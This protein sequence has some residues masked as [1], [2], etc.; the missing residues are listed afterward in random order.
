MLSAVICPTLDYP[1]FIVGTITGTPEVHPSQSSCT[2]KTGKTAVATDTILN[3]KG[4]PSKKLRDPFEEYGRNS[5]ILN[6]FP[7]TESRNPG[8]SISP[9]VRIAGCNSLA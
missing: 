6:K 2:R 8:L 3:Q 5:S 7:K 4:K 9:S 1:S